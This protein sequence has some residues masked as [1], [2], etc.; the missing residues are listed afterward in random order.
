LAWRVVEASPLMYPSPIQER[1]GTVRTVTQLVFHPRALSQP[2]G[3]G[4][5][6]GESEKGGGVSVRHRRRYA[7]PTTKLPT[8]PHKVTPIRH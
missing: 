3:V 7:L 4:V 2:R 1:C 8:F 6:K 5:R